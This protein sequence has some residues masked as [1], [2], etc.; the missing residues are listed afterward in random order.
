VVEAGNPLNLWRGPAAAPLLLSLYTRDDGSV[1]P[2]LQAQLEAAWLRGLGGG[3]EHQLAALAREEQAGEGRSQ[4]RLLAKCVL[5]LGRLGEREQDAFILA[6]V[7]EAAPS[8]L[9]Q[10]W[11]P[12]VA[13]EQYSTTEPSHPATSTSLARPRAALLL[14][15]LLLHRL[16]LPGQEGERSGPG[17]LGDQDQFDP[18]LAEAAVCLAHTRGLPAAGEVAVLVTDLEAAAGGLVS[19]LECGAMSRLQRL[20]RGQALAGE[21]GP[22]AAALA[23]ALRLQ[24]RWQGGELQ[25]AALLPRVDNWRDG[26]LGTAAA[27]LR[28]ASSLGQ[29]GGMVAQ[30]LGVEAARLVSLGGPGH[31][32]AAPSAWLVAR[33]LRLASPAQ[34]QDLQPEV[35]AVL[36]TLPAWRATQEDHLLYSRHLAGVGWP[37]ASVV[38]TVADLLASAVACCPGA[39][40]PALWDLASCSLVSWAASLDETGPALLQEPG[41]ATLAAAVARL[42]AALGRRLGPPSHR[43]AL[44]PPPPGPEGGEEDLPP[45]LREE[46]AEFFSDGVFSALL[47]A[48]VSLAGAPDPAV[49]RPALQA[50]LGAALVCCPAPLLLSTA[51]PPLHL[52]SDVD[53][54]ALPDSLTFLYNHLGPLLQGPGRAGQVTAAHLLATVAPALAAAETEGGDDEEE[55]AVPARLVEAL[56][57]GGAGLG[58][59]LADYRPGE[60]GIPAIPPACAAHTAALGFL[61]TWRVVLALVAAAGQELR[62]RYSE[63]LRAQGHLPLLLDHLFRLLPASAASLPLPEL[64]PAADP[65]GELEALAGSCWIAVCRHLPALA[66][67]WWQALDRPAAAAVERLTSGLV[68]PLLWREETRAID[69]AEAAEN[70]SLRVRD[71]VREVVATYTIDEGSME[72]V[73][74]L[75]A[76]HPLGGLTVESGKRVGVETGQWRK[77]MLQLTTFLTNQNGTI[78]DGLNLWK[79]N[80]DKRFKGVEVRVAFQNGDTTFCLRSATSAS[81]CCMAPTTSCPSW[82]AAPARKSSTLPASSSGSPPPTTLPVPCA[83]TSSEVLVYCCAGLISK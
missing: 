74:T 29:E 26:E 53:C 62:P 24:H 35:A 33:C 61:L 48:F 27:L 23:W 18:L 40:T 49:V 41:P 77:W 25:L 19:Q 12:V 54:P 79:K 8:S 30:T 67:Q 66:R 44:G 81:M 60:P 83:E 32:A 17:V 16:Q 28:L 78:M 47:R 43:P 45:R 46:W 21:A 2:E 3:L 82:A 63:F 7:P 13:Q 64:L 58:A 22:W 34:A 39:L 69:S 56:V 38:A 80:M 70:M 57:R 9:E 37:E 1:R 75:P 65:A 15:R 20:L 5:A 52:A 31:P 14:A 71:T 10:G 76:N 73:V 36:G 68:T 51:L 72:L 50:E 11:G 59:V 4:E 55:R 42:G 6:L